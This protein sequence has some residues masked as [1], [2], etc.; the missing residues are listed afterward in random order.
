MVNIETNKLTPYPL[1]KEIFEELPKT[2]YEALKADIQKNG[3]KTELHITPDFM[4]LCGHQRLR[5]AQELNIPFVPCKIVE[6]LS[7][8]EDIQEYVIKDNLLRRQL[9]PDQQ[10]PLVKRLYDLMDKRIGQ[11]KIKPLSHNATKVDI[12]QTLGNEIGKDRATVA[13]YV[14]VEKAKEKNPEKYKGLKVGQVLRKLK[15]DKQLEEIKDIKPP[16][17]KYNLIVI[18]PPW[19]MEGEYDPEGYR[20]A[21][22]YPTMSIEEIK[23]IKIPADEDAVLWLWA[24][25]SKLKEAIQLIEDWGFTKK[26]T[27][28]WVKPTGGLGWWLRNTHEYCFLCVKGK[29]IFLRQEAGSVLHAPN[30]EHSKKPQEFYDLITKLSPYEKK[31]DYFARAK[32]EGWDIYGDEVGGYKNE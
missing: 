17:G 30:G 13:R 20:G 8:P 14:Q 11:G 23:N 9:T 26:S 25:D 3:I 29:P 21:P 28:I 12:Y 10:A 19:Q 15:I 31:L 22:P 7:T 6:G 27:L 16:T 1:N 5:V 18:D 4:V 2:E 24:I 32:R